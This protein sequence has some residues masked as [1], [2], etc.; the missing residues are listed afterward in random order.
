[1]FGGVAEPVVRLRVQ[2]RKIN[3]AVAVKEVRLTLNPSFF[4][5]ENALVWTRY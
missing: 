3:E 2:V 5:S 1:V 4:I